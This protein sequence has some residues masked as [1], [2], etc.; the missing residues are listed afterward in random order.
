[1]RVLWVA[2]KSLLE[3]VRD[4]RNL[5]LALSLPA[6]FMV[7]FALPY[8]GGLPTYRVVVRDADRGASGRDG[9]PLQATRRLIEALRAERYPDGKAVLE[10]RLVP[11]L[12]AAAQAG[13]AALLLEVGADFSERVAAGDPGAATAVTLIG[14]PSSPA[15]VSARWVV[16]DVLQRTVSALQGLPPPGHAAIRSL[17]P[18]EARTEYDAVVPGVIVFA[19]LLLVAQTAMLMVA[20]LQAG[21]LQRFQLSGAGAGVLFAGVSLS[22][23]LIAAVQVPVITAVALLMGFHASGSLLAAVLVAMIL[24]LSAVGLGLLVSCLARTPAE[25]SNLGAGVLLAVTFLSGA[26]FPVPELGLVHAF[27]RELGPWHLFAATHAYAA[28]R[29]VLVHGAGL[30]DLLFELTATTVLSAAYL[31]LGILVFGRT[32]LRAALG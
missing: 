6:G 3:Q 17:G 1:M 27:G 22:Q 14:D 32:R 13:Q 31:A 19:I 9:A 4:L 10:L 30:G 8:L 23:M 5:L 12:E 18:G 21:T 11:R 28:I 25:A 16:D 20:E 2:W 24:G 29:Q 26:F 15:F 7:V